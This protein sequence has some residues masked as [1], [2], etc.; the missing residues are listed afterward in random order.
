MA[1]VLTFEEQALEGGV[2]KLIETKGSSTLLVV[3]GRSFFIPKKHIREDRDNNDNITIFLCEEWEYSEAKSHYDETTKK[4]VK[5]PIV[6]ESGK[7]LI[8][9]LHQY[10]LKCKKLP[11][12]AEVK[13][14]DDLPF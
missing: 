4:F 7:N 5:D 8:R 12:K 9:L 10:S 11:P 2:I 14:D 6:Y 1:Y 13:V 3:D